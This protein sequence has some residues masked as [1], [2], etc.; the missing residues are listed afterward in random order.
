MKAKILP[1][2]IAIS[3]LAVS[4]SAAFYSVFG[5]SKLF[6]GA[7][8]QVII[9]A[10]SL[11]F[12]KL[13]VAS[14]LYQYWDT[15]NKMLRAYLAIACFVLMIITSGGIYGFLSGAYQSTA[16]QSELLDKSLMIL[17]QKQVRFEET[18]EDLNIEKTQI[19]KSISDLRISL[20]N[21]QQVSW[22]D[23][24]SQTVITST[25][26]SARRALQSELKTTI[27]DRDNINIKIE[28]VMDSINKTDMALL[29]KEVSNE[30]ESELGPLKYLAETTGQPMNEVVNWFL[31]L[32]IFVFDPLAIALVVAANMA[33][34][35]IK[36]KVIMSVPEGMEFNTPYPIEH[37]ITEPSETLKARVK[38][39]QDK[40]KD[41]TPPF[42]NEPME[43]EQWLP[44]STNLDDIPEEIKIKE[45]Q[46][47]V[48]EE[49][50]MNII[51]QNGNDGLH[52]EKEDKPLMESTPSIEEVNK[53]FTKEKS[54]VL[55]VK[56]KIR[57]KNQAPRSNTSEDN[58]LEESNNNMRGIVDPQTILRYKN[59]RK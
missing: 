45:D 41:G 9:M 29:D 3:A 59:N 56:E 51:G 22:F 18:K 4:G 24:N 55:T 20:S 58:K 14:L 23:K 2:L 47:M 38:E 25:S 57:I 43:E 54:K 50:R 7:S 30:A 21:P 16:T 39:N 27:A 12:A 8:L 28:A 17:N 34:A 32:I 48:E 10:G 13:I 36:P 31:L 33:F 1:I 19:N 6:A 49:V 42:I 11:E 40:I 44:E 5:L 35:Q 52:Y 15:I 46:L 26:S 37:N 53:P